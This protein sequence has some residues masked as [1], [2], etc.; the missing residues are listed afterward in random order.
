M[1]RL[2]KL[3]WAGKEH[4]GLIPPDGSLNRIIMVLVFEPDAHGDE[5]LSQMY[6]QSCIRAE[7]C[8]S[9]YIC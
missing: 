2:S 7:N 3:L 8:F 5:L 4:L 1:E 9:H 6:V